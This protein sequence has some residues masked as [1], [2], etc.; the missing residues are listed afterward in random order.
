MMSDLMSFSRRK[1]LAGAVA[2]TTLMGTACTTTGSNTASGTPK[3]LVLASTDTASKIS[4]DSLPEVKVK[5]KFVDPNAKVRMA[6]VGVGGM[7]QGDLFGFADLEDVEVIAL[8]DVDEVQAEKARKKFP[9]VKFYQD[10][11]QMLTEMG[12][13][14]DAMTVSTPDHVHASAALAAIRM[15]KHV[16]VQKPL[17][18]TIYEVQL[19]RI[20]AERH[21]VVTQMGIQ[22]HAMDGWRIMKEWLDAGVIGKVN[23]VQLLTTRPI[24]PQRIPRPEPEPVP[25][26]LKWD[27]WLGPA[28]ERP[29]N[30]LYVP[31]RWRGW[32]DFGTC[33]LGDMGC[34]GF[35]APFS[36]FEL[37]KTGKI[38]ISAVCDENKMESG[39]AWSVVHYEFYDR[40][41]GRPDFKLSWFDGLVQPPRPKGLADDQKLVADGMIF[42]GDKLFDKTPMSIMSG[43]YGENPVLLPE[44]AKDSSPMPEPTMPRIEGE[45]HRL[46]FIRA[47]KGGG[48][49]PGANFEFSCPL[50]EIVLLG[51]LSLR[52][53]ETIVWDCNEHQVVNTRAADK[54]IKQEYRSGWGI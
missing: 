23:E 4:V 43:I 27:L 41:D 48:V 15:G 18:R 8:C 13:Q 35:D 21:G 25:D 44:K 20:E 37:S 38:R 17:A 28:P 26:T 53:G 1:F 16:Y 32:W 9:D 45:N 3:D 46:E 30:S 6:F 5:G 47:V 31:F 39:P 2:A 34:H 22:G 11:R 24:W 19:L 29:Y 51:N 52:S 12:D 42:L 10:F 7:G 49:L 36:I 54:Y 33:A 50:T 40:P 14:I